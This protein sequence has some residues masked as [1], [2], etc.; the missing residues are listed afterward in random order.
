SND[1]P[2]TCS[3]TA[4]SGAASG[5]PSSTSMR[6]SASA[7]GRMRDGTGSA[8]ARRAGVSSSFGI[9]SS[10]RRPGRSA[11][12]W[13]CRRAGESVLAN[14]PKPPPDHGERCAVHARTICT[15]A[16][17]TSRTAGSVASDAASARA[18]PAVT[19]F[20]RLVR[21]IHG[22]VMDVVAGHRLDVPGV[23]A[24]HV[25]R[26]VHVDLLQV[27]GRLLDHRAPGGH[28]HR[29]SDGERHPRT[30]PPLEVVVDLP[31]VPVHLVP[32]DVLEVVVPEVLALRRPLC[33][34][35]LA[36]VLPLRPVRLPRRRAIGPVLLAVPALLGAV[37]RPF[38]P[39]VLA[40]A[41]AI[42]AIPLA[43]LPRLVPRALTIGAVALA[44]RLTEP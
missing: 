24:F 26:A 31:V 17:A 21:W 39:R 44:I 13:R 30:G 3:D 9:S 2:K 22:D 33:G 43:V 37:V 11:H 12:A 18:R 7:S 14:I 41:L 35:L 4:S 28:G 23:R 1:A 8:R 36:Y 34:L 19:P 40:L 42:R 29:R 15:L 16:T 20:V 6:A 38:L 25:H 27:A 32:V 10:L 5:S